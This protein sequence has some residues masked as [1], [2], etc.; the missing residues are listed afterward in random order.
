MAVVPAPFSRPFIVGIDVGTRNVGFSYV[1][2]ETM[3]G[4][5]CIV[6]LNDYCPIISIT[7]ARKAI[8]M[9]IRQHH[10]IFRRTRAFV[11]ED[12]KA[13]VSK[14]KKV[15]AIFSTLFSLYYPTAE[16]YIMDAKITRNYWE[17]SVPS[18]SAKMPPGKRQKMQEK[19]EYDERKE[20]SHMAELL[21]VEDT[22]R[23]EKA[24][25]IG[26]KYHVDAKEAALHVITFLARE[27]ELH[28]SLDKIPLPTIRHR[29]VENVLF[30]FNVKKRAQ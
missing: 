18:E 30:H 4:S 7:K 20:L 3:Y 12:Q 23:E 9:F 27:K 15:Q 16:V 2:E 17:T 24:F 1:N 29:C 28:P 10:H 21:N 25:T 8:L 22:K 26:G 5:E 13:S 19:D 14:M 11:I 6:D